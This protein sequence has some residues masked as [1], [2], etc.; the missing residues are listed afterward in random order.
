MK[1][2]SK[3]WGYEKWIENNREYCGK[4]LHVVPPKWC[5][6]HY[7][8]NKKETFYVIGGELLVVYAAYSEKLAEQVKNSPDPLWDWR[9]NFTD[10]SMQQMLYEFDT[11]LCHSVLNRQFTTKILKQGDCLTINPY[12]L[13][14]FTSN[15]SS[16]CDFI[17]VST[18]HEDSD[19]IRIW[20]DE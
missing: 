2:V 19:S 9:H 20:S 8:K 5:S 3:N 6:F 10:K 15:T 7:H 14:T 4:H 1:F 17:E 16:P 13:H 18:F 12:V 11:P